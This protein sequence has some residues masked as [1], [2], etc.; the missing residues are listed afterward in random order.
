MIAK[1]KRCEKQEEITEGWLVVL[2]A[3]HTSTKFMMVKPWY[4]LCPIC[5]LEY[6]YPKAEEMTPEMVQRMKEVSESGCDEGDSV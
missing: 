5:K 4:H 3:E 6:D 2:A 1:C